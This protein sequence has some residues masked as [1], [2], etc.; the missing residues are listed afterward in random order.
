MKVLLVTATAQE[1]QPLHQ[2]LSAHAAVIEDRPPH[3]FSFGNLEITWLITGV[4]LTFTAF[5][6]GQQ[7]MKESFDMAINA[8]IAGAFPD[9]SLVIGEVVEVK[10]AFFADLGAETAEG[11][12]LNVFELGLINGN[13]FP[14]KSFW[15]ENSGKVKSNLKLVNEVSVNKV[16]GSDASIIALRQRLD[17]DIETME[18]AAFFYA[19]LQHGLPF[20]EI[21]A[22]SNFVEPRNR[23]AWNIPLAVNELNKYLINWIVNISG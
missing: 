2:Y 8:G 4:G 21:R 5:H 15:L 23:D 18:G 16:N 9:A 20:M 13:D 19:C 14:F 3:K 1:V 17:A 10:K 7:L 12:F 11:G 22:I 6:L